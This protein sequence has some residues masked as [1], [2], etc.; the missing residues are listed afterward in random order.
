[1]DV[2]SGY[3]SQDIIPDVSDLECSMTMRIEEPP[4]LNT[5]N[6]LFSVYTSFWPQ[7]FCLRLHME[8]S[9]RKCHFVLLE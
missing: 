7:M 2:D 9:H 1:M 3:H 4:P 6:T 8:L 5:L